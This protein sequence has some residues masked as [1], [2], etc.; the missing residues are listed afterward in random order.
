MALETLPE[1]RPLLSVQATTG[2]DAVNH[3]IVSAAADQSQPP[4]LGVA[5]PKKKKRLVSLDG[6][7][8]LTVAIMILVDNLGEWL[9]S[10]N[11]SPWNIVTLADFVMPYFLFMV[12]CSMSLAFRKYR[13]GL[14]T[15][16]LTRTAKL[17]VLGL[18]TQGSDFPSLGTE[19]INLKTVRIPGILQRIAWA[20]LVVALIVMYVPKIEVNTSGTTKKSYFYAFR[21]HAYQWAV[22][23]IFFWIYLIIMLGVSVPSWDYQYD[24]V[25]MHVECKWWLFYV[26]ALWY[27]R[28][29]V[30]QCFTLQHGRC[31]W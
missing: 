21:V 3:G 19:G 8:G 27:L 25:T 22:A 1:H 12:G 30:Y 10:I 5:Q 4:P 7:R 2:D 31:C 15:K 17:F 26:S 9:P 14:L 28:H 11:H 24:G 16:V 6:V 29:V 18:L 20:Y 23:S 13:K